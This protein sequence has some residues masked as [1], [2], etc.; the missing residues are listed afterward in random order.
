M[1]LCDQIKEFNGMTMLLIGKSGVG[2]STLIKSL[3]SSDFKKSFKV[4]NGIKSTTSVLMH[5]SFKSNV[6]HVKVGIKFKSKEKLRSV[7]FE[8]M[9][10]AFEK[11]MTQ[12]ISGL[13]K[14]MSPTEEKKYILNQLN[15]TA[16][17]DYS[18]FFNIVK[19]VSDER[20]IFVNKIYDDIYLPMEYLFK[21]K[22]SID[23]AKQESEIF[24]SQVASFFTTNNKVEESLNLIFDWLYDKAVT[25]I[26]K[27]GFNKCDN[28]D[29]EDYFEGEFSDSESLS[30]GLLTINNS[31][32][33]NY[34]DSAISS[35]CMVEQIFLEVPR[36]EVELSGG[37]LCEFVVTDSYG[38][39][40]DG[41][42]RINE[43]LDAILLGQSYTSILLLK[44]YSDDDGIDDILKQLM[45]FAHPCNIIPIITKVESILDNIYDEDDVDQDN[46][47]LENLFSKFVPRE[48]NSFKNQ[49]MSFV[50]DEIGFRIGSSVSFGLKKKDSNLPS[51]Y[52]VDKVNRNILSQ[53]RDAFEK[54][55][56]SLKLAAVDI[57]FRD[58]KYY[59]DLLVLSRPLNDFRERIT[60]NLN[61]SI[62]NE[63]KELAANSSIYHGNTINTLIVH[64]MNGSGHTSNARVYG[65]ISTNPFRTIQN[66]ILQVIGRH[67]IKL[68][69]TKVICR[70]KRAEDHLNYSCWV[71]FTTHLYNGL[72]KT[73]AYNNL[74]NSRY[75]SKNKTTLD[76]LWCYDKSYKLSVLLKYIEQL[77]CDPNLEELNEVIIQALRNA[78]L[79][80]IRAANLSWEDETISLSNF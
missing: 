56:V 73:L 61:D 23:K 51:K 19:L 44:E 76:R 5:Y 3:I 78:S 45:E 40:H 36:N 52:S 62:V 7:F 24:K 59:S 12:Y 66:S 41:S 47:S 77:C 15:E 63:Y 27:S 35:I 49:I 32:N 46:S 53:S 30:A 2:K 74:S 37:N 10:S 13:P 21:A 72:I 33:H 50:R 9:L 11:L 28:N 55:K 25:N 34:S 57:V 6:N 18:K 17:K 26:V 29:D 1:S 64:W 42:K 16:I 79:S 20:Q 65:N 38:L 14:N 67:E 8:N 60:I 75:K 80:T 70:D 43:N 48:E 54:A 31:N 58:S 69:K 68:D 39:T 4:L 71:N 22:Q